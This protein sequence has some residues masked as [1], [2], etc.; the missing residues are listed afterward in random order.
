MS[1]VGLS[2]KD[3]VD[4]RNEVRRILVLLTQLTATGGVGHTHHMSGTWCH[5]SA[6]LGFAADWLVEVLSLIGK[7][8]RLI[9]SHFACLHHMVVD[10]IGQSLLDVIAS[11]KHGSTV[12][13]VTLPEQR[14][15]MKLVQNF[16]KRWHHG[17]L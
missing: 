9:T 5:V 8:S 14:I 7:Q 3:F 15:T 6:F 1:F 13:L 2:G 4:S 10:W 11:L 17:S 12:F 16:I